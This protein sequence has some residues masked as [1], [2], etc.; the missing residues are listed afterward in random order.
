MNDLCGPSV[1]SV[2]L[3]YVF[4]WRPAARSR[5][6]SLPPSPPW[7]QLGGASNDRIALCALIDCTDGGRPTAAAAS[8][9]CGV[10][11]FGAIRAA[12]ASVHRRSPLPPAPVGCRRAPHLSGTRIAPRRECERRLLVVVGTRWGEFGAMGGVSKTRRNAFQ[13]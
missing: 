9:P 12:G 7:L 5:L 11:A 4:V 13:L 8:Q 6:P 3:I 1:Y 2:H 10:L